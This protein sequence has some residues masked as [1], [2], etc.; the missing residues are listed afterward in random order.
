MQLLQDEQ[1]CTVGA[2]PV[3]RLFQMPSPGG[4][5]AGGNYLGWGLLPLDSPGGF[6]VVAP[7]DTTGKGG[8]NGTGLVWRVIA[9]SDL[10][11][12]VASKSAAYAATS[13]D[14]TILATAGAVGWTLTLPLA[15]SVSAGFELLIKQ[16]DSGAGTLVVGVSG[17]DK[18]DGASTYTGISAQYGFVRLI[19][20]GSANWYVTGS[21]TA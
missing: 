7:A 9:L 2:L 19:S 21:G 11:T 3:G 4:G 5:I 1:N 18:I 14:H 6:L 8:V 16:I 12:P 17:S 13:T 10:P 20:D 15:A